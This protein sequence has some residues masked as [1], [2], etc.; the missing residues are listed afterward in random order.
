MDHQDHLVEGHQA[1]GHQVVP[2]E[3][4]RRAE[5]CL[6]WEEVHHLPHHLVEDSLEDCLAEATV[7]PAAAVEEAVG[8][9]TLAQP[10]HTMPSQHHQHGPQN[11]T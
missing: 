7:D 5:G 10:H 6:E 1:E 8:H 4:Y 2:L 3:G 9:Q 11:P